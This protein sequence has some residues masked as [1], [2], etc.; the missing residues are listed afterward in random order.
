MTDS[1]T[2]AWKRVRNAGTVSLI[3]GILSLVG[4]V[5]LVGLGILF[6][7]INQN[8]TPTNCYGSG[9]EPIP[10]AVYGVIFIVLAILFLLPI[11][12]VDIIAGV[13]LRKPIPKPKGWIIYVVVIGALGIS[14]ITGILMLIFGVLG[15]ATLH[16]VEGTQPPQLT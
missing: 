14:S 7:A 10:S 16:E 8:I 3:V 5:F 9:C 1:Q 12:I 11:G 2:L 6:F 15:L 13:K 4:V